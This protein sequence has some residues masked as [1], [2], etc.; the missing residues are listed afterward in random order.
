MSNGRDSSGPRRD[1][2]RR[3]LFGAGVVLAYFGLQLVTQILAGHQ[4]G[5]IAAQLAQWAIQMAL[6]AGLLNVN[7]GYMKRRRAGPLLTLVSSAII[8][9][10]IGIICSYVFS[11]VLARW[12][13]LRLRPGFPSPPPIQRALTFGLMT[14]LLH[15]GFWV[16]AFVFPF[17]AEDARIRA[18]EAD[19]LR[20]AAEVAHL[21][22]HLEPHFMLNTL[23]AIAGLVTEDPK[24]ARRLIATLGD[25]L[26][27]AVRQD[28]DRYTVDDEVSWL[29]RYAELLEAR[30]E[31]ALEF[32]WRIDEDVRFAMIP[33]MLLQPLVENAVKHGALKRRDGGMVIVTAKK[34]QSPSGDAFLVCT[35]VDNGP[36][37]GEARK[38]SR[39]LSV[40][41]TQLS[42]RDPRGTLRLESS[43]EGT[44]SVVELPLSLS[45][46]A[47]AA[48]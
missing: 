29:R 30:H 33:R 9:G 27:E 43:E 10:I 32:D 23:N 37:L 5:R 11:L 31:G 20:G 7:Y 18:L 45:D 26:R 36:G 3:L 46:R 28:E 19:R 41:R 16:M 38:D 39:G 34:E 1:Q 8:S 21:R 6:I 17:A 40:V 22:A 24:K 13:E 2:R 42:L 12:P 14:G 47:E 4:P 25:L 44:R 48:Q 15:G 35:V